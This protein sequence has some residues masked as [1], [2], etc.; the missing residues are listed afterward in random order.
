MHPKDK[1]LYLIFLGLGIVVGVWAIRRELGI[2][3]EFDGQAALL[4]RGTEIRPMDVT[5]ALGTTET[6]ATI[7]GFIFAIPAAIL[8]FKHNRWLRFAMAIFL[9]LFCLTPLMIGTRS[10]RQIIHSHGL[11]LEE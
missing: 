4:S 1:R 3:H 6:I 2:L 9:L 8:S 5:F 7:G 10:F 11:V